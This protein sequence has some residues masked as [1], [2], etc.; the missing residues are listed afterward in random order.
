MF[1][2]SI[3][4]KIIQKYNISESII[5]RPIHF[6]IPDL[7]NIQFQK[8]PSY[9][10][11]KSLNGSKNIENNKIFIFS[12]NKRYLLDNNS[13]NQKYRKKLE[14][15]LNEENP[16]KHE[17]IKNCQKSV[18]MIYEIKKFPNKESKAVINNTIK[19]NHKKSTVFPNVCRNLKLNPKISNTSDNLFLNKF[20]TPQLTK[21]KIKNRIRNLTKF[22]LNAKNRENNIEKEILIKKVKSVTHNKQ[23][24]K[25]IKTNQTKDQKTQTVNIRKNNINKKYSYEDSP[26]R[27]I[28]SR[29]FT[30]NSIN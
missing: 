16:L 1:S 3:K 13:K 2:N 9:Y 28:K 8:Y 14:L 27:L 5:N 19:K 11:S 12:Y 4:N 24:I 23:S 15:L 10:S 29:Y 18:K 7:V 21:I 26:I 22:P 25:T 6:R 20:F 17:L 30:T